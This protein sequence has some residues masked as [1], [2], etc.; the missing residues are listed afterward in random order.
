[1]IGDPLN[2]VIRSIRPPHSYCES[3]IRVA[4]TL[5]AMLNLYRHIVL[6]RA[7]TVVYVEHEG[8][9]FADY[10]DAALTGEGC[11]P[12]FFKGLEVARSLLCRT[13]AIGLFETSPHV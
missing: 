6:S 13:S 7:G 8:R 5:T 9:N 4:I 1:M 3:M 2:P 10:R 12:R 11:R